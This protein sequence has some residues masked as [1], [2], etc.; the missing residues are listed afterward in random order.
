MKFLLKTIF[1]MCGILYRVAVLVTL[2]GRW[3][4]KN[5]VLL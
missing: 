4:T 3:L 2:T 1:I 5:D